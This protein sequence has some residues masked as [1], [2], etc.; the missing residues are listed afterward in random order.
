MPLYQTKKYLKTCV[1]CGKTEL[2]QKNQIQCHECYIAEVNKKRTIIR[3]CVRCGRHSSFPLT[4][5]LCSFCLKKRSEENI[6]NR[7]GH[8][9]LTCGHSIHPETYVKYE[10]YCQ[11]CFELKEM[12]E[13]AK[14]ALRL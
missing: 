11:S 14:N 2:M 7:K 9:C 6:A 1:K 4:L 13:I 3:I 12:L 8:H 5:G 10:G